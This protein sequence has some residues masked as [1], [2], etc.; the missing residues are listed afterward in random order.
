MYMNYRHYQSKLWVKY[1]HKTG[2]GC[3]MLTGYLTPGRCL[4]VS[5]R[6]REIG[7]KDLLSSFQTESTSCRSY[8]HI[9]F[10]VHSPRARGGAFIIN[11]IITLCINY[12]I[13]ICINYNAVINNNYGRIQNHIL[14]FKI[15]MRRRNDFYEIYTQ[16]GM[17]LQKGLPSLSLCVCVDIHPIWSSGDRTSW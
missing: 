17:R 16:F 5:K 12:I 3:E 2:E 13:I 14:L 9:F 6:I 1:F 15:S 7:Q 4:A 11:I 8:F 10:R